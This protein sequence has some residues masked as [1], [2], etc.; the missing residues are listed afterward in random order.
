MP[1]VKVQTNRGVEGEEEFLK[2]LSAELADK[3]G[4]PES[5]V[6]TALQPELAMTFGGT[7][8]KTA[9]VELKSIGLDESM[10]ADLSDFICSF[11]ETE[12]GI[13]QARVYIDFADSPGA[14]W[15]WDG[16]TF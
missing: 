11:M 8:E 1:F 13:D 6:M 14:M 9:F 12:L 15:G 10:T 2:K 7:T 16:G 3:L 5:Y 4:K